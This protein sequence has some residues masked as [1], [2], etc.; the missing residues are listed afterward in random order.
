MRK[1]LLIDILTWLY[2]HNPL[3]RDIIINYDMLA[4]MSHEFILEDISYSVVTMDNDISEQEGYN[5]SL[6]ENNDKNDLYFTINFAKNNHSGILC[7]C[8]Y[9]DG[10]E[11][12]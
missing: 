3:Y 6:A 1:K 9:I 7:G 11:L 12:R 4:N 5:A 8:I 10:N 2:T